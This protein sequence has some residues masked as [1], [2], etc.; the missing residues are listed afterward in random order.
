MKETMS[1]EK[2]RNKIR[3][4]DKKTSTKKTKS[5]DKKSKD[6]SSCSCGR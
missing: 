1:A 2:I 4:E 3:G 5:S 6:H